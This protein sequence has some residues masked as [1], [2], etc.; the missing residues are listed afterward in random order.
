MYW[1]DNSLT[2]DTKVV[3]AIL[4]TCKARHET[5]FV[6]APATPA[7]RLAA[8]WQAALG[9]SRSVEPEHNQLQSKHNIVYLKVEKQKH[10]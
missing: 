3:I 1:H 8:K 6:A 5:L 9:T 10:W 4:P 2:I 7:E